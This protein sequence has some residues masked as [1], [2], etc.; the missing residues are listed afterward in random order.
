V[1]IV[2]S[3]EAA[4]KLPE[5]EQT[6]LS[7]TLEGRLAESLEKM[8]NSFFMRYAVGSDSLAIYPRPELKH[9]IGR[10]TAGELNLLRNIYANPMWT[11]TN[12]KETPEGLVQKAFN[13][14]AKEPVAI[15][16]PDEIRAV[17]ETTYKMMTKSKSSGSPHDP[18]APKRDANAPKDTPLTIASILEGVEQSYNSQKTW[19]VRGP[20][21]PRQV[22]EIRIVSKQEFR[23]T[24]LDQ[25]I[26]VSFTGER[27]ESVVRKL[28]AWAG[29][30]VQID[31][32][33][34]QWFDRE[35][36][37][38]VQNVKLVDALYKALSILSVDWDMT[39]GSLRLHFVTTSRPVSQ[40]PQQ[41][42][43]E[44]QTGGGYVGK[45]SIPMD[46]GRYFIEFMLRESD[47]PEQ[48]RKLRQ[49]AMTEVITELSSEEKIKEVLKQLSN[50]PAPK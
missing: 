16:S 34:A 18:N 9:I 36:T 32:K 44:S 25:V 19:Y 43:G 12:A 6:R 33:A 47:L 5:G 39:E 11:S 24:Q 22:S 41:A 17:E 40:P 48:L 46:G 23:Q 15:M 13:A 27:G 29:L 1:K 49:Q 30:D 31:P 21:F 14:L 3:P 8:L 26:D 37:L 45:I 38:E 10:P 50:S 7:V 20:E 35:I 42:A 2:L 4:W 28:A